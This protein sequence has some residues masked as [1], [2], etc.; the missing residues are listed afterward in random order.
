MPDLANLSK[1]NEKDNFLFQVKEGEPYEVEVRDFGIPEETNQLQ[2]PNLMKFRGPPA[3]NEFWWYNLTRPSTSKPPNSHNINRFQTSKY[4]SRVNELQNLSPGAIQ[5]TI[6]ERGEDELLMND[7]WLNNSKEKQPLTNTTPHAWNAI[8]NL[9]DARS[10]NVSEIYNFLKPPRL[11]ETSIRDYEF[12][13]PLI[14]IASDEKNQEYE[15]F[16]LHYEQDKNSFRDLNMFPENIPTY[17]KN[18][19]PESFIPD[20]EKN[21]NFSKVLNNLSENYSVEDENKEQPK[22]FISDYKSNN[23]LFEETHHDQDKNFFQDF[24]IYPENIPTY[25]KNQEHEGFPPDSEKNL[26]FLQDFNILSERSSAEEETKDQPEGFILD[27]KPNKGIF[28]GI[29]IFSERILADRNNKEQIK[30]FKNFPESIDFDRKN[31]NSVPLKEIDF[32]NEDNIPHKQKFGLQGKASTVASGFNNLIGLLLKE[33]TKY[34]SKD[35][36]EEKNNRNNSSDIYQEK[37]QNNLFKEFPEVN[38]NVVD[39]ND[40][41]EKDPTKEQGTPFLQIFNPYIR[42]NSKNLTTESSSQQKEEDLLLK[43]LNAAKQKDAGNMKI[44]NKK[45]FVEIK[46]LSTKVPE[47]IKN[48]LDNCYCFVQLRI[49]VDWHRRGGN[50]KII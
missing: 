14:N 48:D 15:Q 6:P 35:K 45:K 22:E 38:K 26:N 7:F 2:T 44:N 27:S 13:N 29:D 43:L 1:V 23:D 16:N 50:L 19:K 42:E 32:H 39:Y 41:S 46:E 3:R 31:K 28:Q 17:R 33:E 40:I 30:K 5:A 25:R 34:S 20:S 10:R 36:N 47:E 11:T 24:N 8:K 21:I 37:F 18:K 4:T 9:I 49:A 12:N